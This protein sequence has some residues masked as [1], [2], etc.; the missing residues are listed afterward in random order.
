M[1]GDRWLG[2]AE[3][4]REFGNTCTIRLLAEVTDQFIATIDADHL[5]TVG[6]EL[7]LSHCAGFDPGGTFVCF[8]SLTR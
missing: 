8:F 2:Q 4:V 1:V 7:L 3:F 5:K 6:A